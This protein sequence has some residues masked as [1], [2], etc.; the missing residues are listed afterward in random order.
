MSRL[1]G[2]PNRFPTAV[3]TSPEKPPVNISSNGDVG[4]S[5]PQATFKGCWFKQ[6]KKRYQAVD[7]SV[8]VPG[9]YAFNAILYHGTTCT[10]DDFADQIGFGEPLNFGGFGY[11]FWFDAFANQKNMS[12]IWYLGNENSKCVNYETAP[13]C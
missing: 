8:G 10:P 5:N 6:G 11:T 3:S 12:A 13:P 1:S 9:S 4:E 7:L 2:S